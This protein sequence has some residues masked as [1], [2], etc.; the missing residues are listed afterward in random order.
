MK[1]IYWIALLIMTLA[2]PLQAA[3]QTN[4]PMEIT[5]PD[6]STIS[7][8][9]TG[10]EYHNWLNDAEGYTIIQDKQTGWYS[11]AKKA[12]NYLE[13]SEYIVGQSNPRTSGL[14]PYLNISIEEYQQRR[15]A[16]WQ[17][18]PHSNRTP[19]SGQINNIVIFIR[20]SDQT[21]FTGLLSSYDSMFNNPVPNTNSMYNY[22]MEDSY[23]NLSITTTFYP[24]AIED[25]IVSY[26]DSNP[27]NYYTP[28]N[29]TNTIGYSTDTERRLREHALLRDAVNYV[30]QYIPADLDVD[31]DDDGSVDNVCFVV[32]GSSGA[33]ADLLWPHMWELY[34]YD[35]FINGAVVST[36]NFQLENSLTS[37]G[38]GVLCHEMSHS[39]GMPDLYHYSSNGISPVGRWDLMESNRNPP[40]H[41][42]TY[43]KTRYTDWM[44]P[45][46]TITQS[47][48][49]WV[50]KM[51]I[52]QNNCYRIMSN[53][54]QYY[55]VVEFRKTEGF[56]EPSLPGSGM[57]IFRIDT[58]EDGDG[59]ADGPP[60]EVYVYR[61]GGTPTSNGTVNS[62]FYSLEV[63]RTAINETT[64]PSAFLGDGQFG[65]L[66]IAQIGS[67]AGDSISFFVTLP[68]PPPTDYDEGFESG[69]FTTY[70]WAFSGNAAWSITNTLPY[71][72]GFCA[73][74]NPID[75][76]QNSTMLMTIDVPV[77]GNI[78]FFKKVSS[79]AGYDY[80]KF[81]IDNVQKGQWAGNSNWSYVQFPIEPGLRELKWS[82][83]KDQGVVSGS[84]CA[85]VDNISFRWEAIDIHYPPTDFTAYSIAEDIG[86]Q[87]SW[88]PPV[89]SAS[90]LMG[91]RI[92]KNGVQIADLDTTQ[93]GFS[94]FYVAP[95]QSYSYFI[96][97]F[98]LNPYG[99]SFSTDT[100]TV[101]VEGIPTVPIITSAEV[102]DTNSVYIQW[103]LPL[104]DRGVIG[105]FVYRNGALVQTIDG[106]SLMEWTDQDLNWGEYSYQ[107]ASRYTAVASDPSEAV[108]VN[109]EEPVDND[110]SIIP[111]LIFGIRR[112]YPNPFRTDTQIHYCIDKDNSFTDISIYNLKGQKVRYLLRE[113]S[114]AGYQTI[115]WNG[116]DDRG[117]SVAPGVYF[118][119]MENSGKASYQK[120]LLIK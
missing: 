33:W 35:A 82:Y 40:Q 26:Q 4:V 44:P 111:S 55:F 54:A 34:T 29:S 87:L 2:L 53:S 60:D 94:D 62:A 100:L 115:T 39:I 50:N 84:D 27:R 57:L 112:I 75:H 9:A 7:C 119:R 120:L 19:T 95:N 43:M 48:E 72:G 18:A 104:P 8:F 102:V 67:S 97:S 105:Y 42:C 101:T 103:M 106:D 3:F 46:R 65:G 11:Y 113:N 78:G 80:L 20:F 14:Q 81:Y 77:A 88:M 41:H 5:Q 56:F 63:G 66:N 68:S 36:Y 10:D 47:G 37:S 61:P 15:Q 92:F 59:N 45:M 52:Q 31:S 90:T 16:W 108:V 114:K 99:H 76:N 109:V 21:E 107:V 98:Y 28:Y 89:P 96:K 79:E 38:V 93:L 70:P 85:W 25:I 23:Q 74:S 51:L 49:Y 22:F 83:V 110:E 6:G 71:E 12:G 1:Q 69:D 86:I 58:S 116:M 30:A 91:Y 64:N 17:D 13:P 73:Q 117:K 118:C 24:P 32:K